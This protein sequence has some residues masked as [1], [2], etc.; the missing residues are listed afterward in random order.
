[1]TLQQFRYFRDVG[2]AGQLPDSQSNVV[3]RGQAPLRNRAA[4]L[5]LSTGT[6]GRGQLCCCPSS[7]SAG[8]GRA[9]Q[10]SFRCR[11]ARST[12]NTMTSL[13]PRGAGF[14]GELPAAGMPRIGRGLGQDL[15][16]LNSGTSTT[17]S[18]FVA[19]RTTGGNVR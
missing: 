9:S 3:F 1:M 7:A 6:R 18:E 15:L 2:L 8:P 13:S 16:R 14:G 17:F 4:D 11:R 19:M 12:A 5:A 10:W